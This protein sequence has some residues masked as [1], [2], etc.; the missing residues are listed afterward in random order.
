MG[1]SWVNFFQAVTRKEE[2][3]TLGQSEMLANVDM[4]FLYTFPVLF[5]VFNIIYWPYWLL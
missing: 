4:Y 3:K 5:L 2:L 1:K